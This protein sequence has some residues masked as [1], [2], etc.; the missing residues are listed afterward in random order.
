MVFPRL[1]AALKERFLW[2]LMSANDTG[3]LDAW[4]FLPDNSWEIRY[5]LAEMKQPNSVCVGN[6][7][8]GRTENLQRASIIPE[9]GSTAIE[10]S[11]VDEKPNGTFT[12]MM[13]IGHVVVDVFRRQGP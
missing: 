10:I 6:A 5:S 8:D 3:R 7:L 1:D 2:T 9:I 13:H 11:K 12:H 4:E